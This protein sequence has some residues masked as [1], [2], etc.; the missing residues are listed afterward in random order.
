VVVSNGPGPAALQ[1][2]VNLNVKPDNFLVNSQGEVKINDFNTSRV[3]YDS[4]GES[5]LVPT[6]MGTTSYL[7]RE[8]FDDRLGSMNN[9]G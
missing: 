7:S 8:R 5:F 9:A 1:R 6:S 3:V 4:T 2:L